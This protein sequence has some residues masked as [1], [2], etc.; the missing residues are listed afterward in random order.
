MA[1]YLLISLLL[2]SCAG[3]SNYRK[4]KPTVD[5]RV[6]T[7]AIVA[8]IAGYAEYDTRLAP[9][10]SD[11]IHRWFDP[12]KSDSLIRLA[13]RVREEQRISFDAVMS[14]DINLTLDKNKFEFL[15]NWEKDL[16][17][18]W[19]HRDALE[20]VRLLN[21][22]YLQSK[23]SEFFTKQQP[24]YDLIIDRFDEVLTDFDQEWFH[25]FYG[26]E[27][28][29]R[30]TVIIGCGNGAGNYGPGITHPDGR[31]ELYAIMGNS[32]TDSS[33]QPQFRKESY[34]P[35]LL[36]EFN[37]SF[38][39][40]LLFNYQKNAV[41]SNSMKKIYD[42]IAVQMDAQAYGQWD[43][44]F[45]ESIVRAA[46]IRYLEGHHPGNDSLI[47][48]AIV[49]EENNSF[50]WTRELVDMM[51]QYENNRSQFSEFGQFYPRIIPL[52]QNVADSISW[53]IDRFQQDIPIITATAPF[54]N[55]SQEVDPAIR[56]MV[57]RF[58]EPIYGLGNSV[59][60]VAGAE[61]DYPIQSVI[62]LEKDRTAVR[63]A[64]NLAPDRAY[65][66]EITGKSVYNKRGYRLRKK[67]I[68]FR[69]RPRS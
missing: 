48:R 23:A 44:V 37:H 10:Y 52:V 5:R 57:I 45:N 14:L 21:E 11:S 28:K 46:V 20:F 1:K 47:E 34:L 50:L 36:H 7:L 26:V 49:E 69:T 8:R 31:R 17:G 60:P 18:R 61:E 3:G 32:S 27:P 59:R 41:L 56:E 35:I 9:Q 55:G 54:E 29:D 67:R 19:I 63:L 30:F 2:L 16:D 6:E 22:F 58:D 25:S 64:L 42:S 24:Y 68:Y 4:I 62:G 38:V 51:R 12:F 13:K 66:F 39:N 40:P 65:Q 43:A 53:Y 33:G 15:P